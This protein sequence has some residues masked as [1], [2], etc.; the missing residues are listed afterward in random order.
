V[1]GANFPERCGR[2]SRFDFNAGKEI[3][4]EGVDIKPR[5]VPRKADCT[6]R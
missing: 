6:I 3:A 2:F 5:P 4:G 1:N